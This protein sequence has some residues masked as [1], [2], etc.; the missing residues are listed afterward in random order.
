[1]GCVKGI[2]MTEFPEQGNL[3]NK[4]VKVCF[5]YEDETIE[6][7]VIRHDTEEPLRTIIELKDG[8][9]VL[10]TECQYMVKQR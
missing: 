9:V 3:L 7:K 6:G 1:M 8:R 5:N 10:D 2:S 4:K